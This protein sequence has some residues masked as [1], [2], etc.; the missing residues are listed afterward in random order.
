MPQI[1]EKEVTTE[2]GTHSAHFGA[3]IMTQGYKLVDMQALFLHALA[4]D[5]IYC[6]F[7][8]MKFLDLIF[9][10]LQASMHKCFIWQI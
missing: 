2:S 4:L 9:R 3:H 1:K 8:G 7:I 10:T 6:P 5:K